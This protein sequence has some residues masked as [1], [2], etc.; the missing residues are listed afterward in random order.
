MDEN[1]FEETEFEETA[2]LEPQPSGPPGREPIPWGAILLSFWA[3][4]LVVFAV[5]NAED[6]TITFLAWDWQMPVAL[7]V[8]ITALIT[9]V[10]TVVGTAFYRRRRRRQ[11]TKDV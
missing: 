3:V 6:A 4:L 1:E 2:E 7:V 10:I 9:L 11:T 8:I 5:Q